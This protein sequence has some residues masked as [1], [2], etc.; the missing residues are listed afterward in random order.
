MARTYSNLYEQICQY[1]NLY[2]AYERARK[3]KRYRSDV[4]AYSAGLGENL[5]GLE[6]ALRRERWEPGDYRSRMIN[7]PKPRLIRIAPFENRIVHQA[8]CAVTA[9]LFE[10]TFIY[11]SYACREGKGSH[12]ALDRLTAFLRKRGGQYV[13]KGDLRKFFDSIPHGL[14]MRELEWRIAD[15]QTLGLARKILGSYQSDF[16][17]QPG[18]D[19]RGLPIGNLTSQW[20]ANIVGNC[21]DQHV[22]HTLGCKRYLRYMDDWLLIGDSKEQLWTWLREIRALLDGVGLVLNPKTRILRAQDGVPF[23]GFRVWPTHRRLL[24]SNLVAGRRRLRWML[25][26]V[27]RG[28][29]PGEDAVASLRSWFA[30]LAHADTD[31]LRRSLWREAKGVLRGYV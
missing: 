8:F 1:G 18:F 28:D 24:R 23:L 19:P 16:E 7:E 4:L 29:L 11:D 6:R 25:E 15:T 21:L 31:A 13:L 3:G 17:G 22:K 5:L 2:T 27:R 30:H 26:D 12:A 9:P 20:F 14:V 10:E